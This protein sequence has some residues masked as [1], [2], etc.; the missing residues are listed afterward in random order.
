[1]SCSRLPAGRRSTKPCLP[2]PALP[3]T[4]LPLLRFCACCPQ[5]EEPGFW[6]LRRYQFWDAKRGAWG[7]A[8]PAACGVRGMSPQGRRWRNGSPRSAANCNDKY[9]IYDNLWW[10]PGSCPSPA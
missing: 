8:Q 4:L 9:C 5:G 1:M 3:G 2:G 7:D 10:V 6:G